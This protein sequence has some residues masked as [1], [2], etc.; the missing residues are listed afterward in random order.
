MKRFKITIRL[1]ALL[2]LLILASAGLQ[3]QQLVLPNYRT[4]WPGIFNPAHGGSHQ[5]HEAVM[6]HQQRGIGDDGWSQSNLF[7]NYSSAPF[8]K[9]NALGIGLQ[10]FGDKDHTEQQYSFNGS[11]AANFQAKTYNYLRFSTGI[12]IGL[13]NWQSN[14]NNVPITD[15]DDPIIANPVNF[16]DLN[17]GLGAEFEYIDTSLLKFKLGFSGHRLAG[18]WASN[19]PGAPNFIIHP[20]FTAYAGIQYIRSYNFSIGPQ[21]FFRNTLRG[22]DGRIVAAQLDLGL[23]AEFPDRHQMWLSGA[24]RT[25]GSF[26]KASALN[27][28]LG[29]TVIDRDTSGSTP[30]QLKK[31]YLMVNFVSGFSMPLGETSTLG[32]SMEIGLAFKFGRRD[33]RV[34]KHDTVMQQIT[35]WKDNGSLN[36]YTDQALRPPRAGRIFAQT[37]TT[38]TTTVLSF[39]FHDET[40]AYIGE[41]PE[42]DKSG[43]LLKKIGT[44]WPN[45]DALMEKTVSAIIDQGLHPDTNRVLNKAEIDSLHYLMWVELSSHLSWTQF[46]LESPFE[47]RVYEGELGNYGNKGDTLRILV[48]YDMADSLV[49]ILPGQRLNYFQF[50]VLQLHTLRKRLE[51]ELREY[52][53]GQDILVTWEENSRTP[54]NVEK[55][56]IS[57]RVERVF[58]RKLRITTDNTNQEKFQINEVRMKFRRYDGEENEGDGTLKPGKTKQSEQTGNA[59]SRRKAKQEKRRK[60]AD[61]K[62]KQRQEKI[63]RKHAAKEKAATEEAAPDEFVPTKAASNPPKAKQAKVKPAPRPAKA[64]KVKAKKPKRKKAKTDD[65]WMFDFE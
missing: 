47:N 26:L 37:D 16:S 54:L 8:G 17:I 9:K 44:E 41:N 6:L 36:T 56:Y 50:T 60:Q 45:M 18:N 27:F 58:F 39:R 13:M 48:L 23:R 62:E 31:D 1:S 34:V 4:M 11:M 14:Y 12:S 52:Y 38:D 35:F 28:G 43:R 51:Y 21:A 22:A 25:G 15:R 29:F 65:S 10:L 46:G 40:S 49:E 61:E 7:A 64:K 55:D 24:Y 3:A 33:Q 53:R 63:A 5:F 19:D 42:M 59:K 20:Q 30:A 2:S 32:P 57:E